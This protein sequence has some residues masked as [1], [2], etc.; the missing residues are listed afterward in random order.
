MAMIKQPVRFV[1]V[2]SNSLHSLPKRMDQVGGLSKDWKGSA[3]IASLVAG[4]RQERP[5]GH[6]IFIFATR[7]IR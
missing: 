3:I 2:M 6:V 1:M 7:I 5:L 4:A